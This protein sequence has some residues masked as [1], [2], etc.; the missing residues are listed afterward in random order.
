MKF[1]AEIDDAHV[2]LIRKILRGEYVEDDHA[3]QLLIMRKYL[4]DQATKAVRLATNLGDE[5]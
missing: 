1:E 3:P 2:Y 4:L 5:S